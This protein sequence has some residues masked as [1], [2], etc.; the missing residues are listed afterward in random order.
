MI[1]PA[2]ATISATDIPIPVRPISLQTALGTT[3]EGWAIR[4][5]EDRAT[6][7][8][9]H[10]LRGSR[11][12]MRERATLLNQHG[13][14]VVV[15]D[16]QAHG[17]SDGD[18]ITM[19]HL[20]RHG[21]AAAA[22]FARE[23]AKGRRVVV[24]GVSLGGASFLLSKHT[25]VDGVILESVY[26]TISEAV[27]DRVALRIGSLAAP[28]LA[29]TLLLQMEFRLGLSCNDLRPIDHLPKLA[30]PV[31]IMSGSED[32]HTTEQET[33]RMFNCLQQTEA[34]HPSHE[35]W[36]VDGAAHVDLYD[37]AG[38]QYEKRVLNFLD[39]ITTGQ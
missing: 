9:L 3:V 10:G 24:L 19:G 7:V 1:A 33:R 22:K 31:L 29:K 28:P 11:L 37:V 8:L 18:A 32:L 27:H 30:C 38:E 16:L 25:D 2:L 5:R 14:S 39:A 12:T 4:S 34:G 35:L 23:F 17:E 26:P 13:Y 15:I 20:E 6:V 21:A 36:V